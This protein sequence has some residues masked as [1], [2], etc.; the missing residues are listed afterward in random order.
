MDTGGF[1]NGGFKF[2]VPFPTELRNRKH[3]FRV[4]APKQFDSDYNAKYAVYYGLD[5]ETRPNENQTEQFNNPI[6]IKDRLLKISN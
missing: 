6:Y 2:T 4:K 1:T 3:S 5:Y